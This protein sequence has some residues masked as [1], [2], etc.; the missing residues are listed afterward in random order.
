MTGENP[1][2]RANARDLGKIS[3]FG[4]NEKARLLRVAQ[5]MLCVFARDNPISSFEFLRP[6]RL[7]LRF[8]L[9]FG[10]GSV[11]LG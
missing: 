9:V 7:I 8:R 5:D 4:R 2:S 1:S 3:P 10:C 6:L 11:A